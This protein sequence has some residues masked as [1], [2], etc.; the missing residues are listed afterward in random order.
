MKYH[1]LTEI[2]L[3]LEDFEHSADNLDNPGLQDFLTW[4]ILNKLGNV[5]A[6]PEPDWEGKENGRSP[7]SAITTLLVHLNRYARTYSRAAIE[8]SKFS[9][10]DDFSYLINLKAFGEMTKMELIK[11]NIQDKPTGVQIINRLIKNGWV[12]QRASS[13]DRRSKILKITAGGLEALE[14]QMGRIRLASRIVT[15]N[16][17]HHDKMTLISLLNKLEAFH[18]PIFIKQ[19]NAKKLLDV[20]L[21]QLRPDELPTGLQPG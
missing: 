4:A 18:H 10:Q 19:A 15:A 21:E 13:Q 6:T 2:M 8:G 17:N 3:L 20:A 5:S 7:E 1:L 14:L 16:L 11:K 9:T 12:M